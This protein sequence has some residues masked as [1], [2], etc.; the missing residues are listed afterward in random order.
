MIVSK[1]A[2][3][4]MLEKVAT[5][6]KDD[7]LEWLNHQPEFTQTCANETDQSKIVALGKTLLKGR[8]ADHPKAP[9]AKF[10]NS[11][12]IPEVVLPDQR[13]E[14]APVEAGVASGA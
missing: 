1:Y 8:K 7:Q 12:E 6:F 3:K 5:H 14:G 4:K 10:V 9:P 2:R 11:I 13:D